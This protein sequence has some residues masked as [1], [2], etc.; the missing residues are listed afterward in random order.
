MSSLIVSFI[1]SSNHCILASSLLVPVWFFSL[2]VL[3][4]MFILMTSSSSSKTEFTRIFYDVFDVGGYVGSSQLEVSLLFLL[5]YLPCLFLIYYRLLFASSLCEFWSLWSSWWQA[6]VH[7]KRSSLASS[8]MFSMLEVMSVLLS[9]RFHSS[10][11]WHT[12]PASSYYIIGSCLVLLFVSFGAYG[13]LADKLEFIENG[14]HSHRLWCFRC[15]RLCRYFDATRRLVSNKL[16]FA[17]FGAHLQKLWQ[18]WFYCFL[19][20]SL[21]AIWRQPSAKAFVACGSTA[22]GSGST[23]GA[24]GSTAPS[25]Q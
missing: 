24:R 6:R 7:R 14:V 16:E 21:A 10:I 1:E 12:S 5:A 25:E 9:W 3:E 23:T 4:L 20:L 2:W 11:S 17:Q 22:Q 8:M 13:H 15:W 18:F 19:L